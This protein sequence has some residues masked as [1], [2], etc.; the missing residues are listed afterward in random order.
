VTATHQAPASIRALA[1]HHEADVTDPLGAK[2]ARQLRRY[3]REHV[4]ARHAA[5]RGDHAAAALARAQRDDAAAILEG[6]GVDVPALESD[7]GPGT[8]RPASGSSSSSSSSSRG[9]GKGARRPPSSPRRRLAEDL[10]G[11]PADD[12]ERLRRRRERDAAD[13]VRRPPPIRRATRR[14][15][16]GSEAEPASGRSFAR[17]VRRDVGRAADATGISGGASSAGDMIAMVLAG[18][19]GLAVLLRLLTRGGPNLIGLMGEGFVNGLHRL[20][21]PID[22][23]A[24]GAVPSSSGTGATTTSSSKPAASSSSSSAA[25]ASTA[26]AIA[27]DPRASRGNPYRG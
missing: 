26:R 8:R 10:I 11:P 1:D 13:G 22:P 27:A 9:G 24:P 7:A 4:K 12:L 25:A 16:R 23:L 21:D 5:K 18:T 6:W 15:L 20:V 19:I 17:D 2:K 14:V 3:G